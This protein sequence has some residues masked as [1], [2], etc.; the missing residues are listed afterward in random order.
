ME[1]Q[2]IYQGTGCLS[3]QLRKKVLLSVLTVCTDKEDLEET[4]TRFHETWFPQL[5]QLSIKNPILLPLKGNLLR[6]PSGN[7]P[8]TPLVQEN[9][10][11]LLA[12]TVSGKTYM[13]ENN[14]H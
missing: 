13:Q 11:K 2:P 9:L 8:P 14:F 6:D 7:C 4:T 5:L 12:W 1:A 3:N 10:F